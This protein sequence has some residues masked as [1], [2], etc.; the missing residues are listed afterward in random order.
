MFVFLL[1]DSPCVCGIQY[2]LSPCDIYGGWGGVLSDPCYPVNQTIQFNYTFLPGEGFK[3][4]LDLKND[5]VN[6][7]ED[8]N[9]PQIIESN[10]SKSRLLQ[11]INMKNK[12]SKIQSEN[13]INPKKKIP[14]ENTPTPLQQIKKIRNQKLE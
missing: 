10:S 8:I 2:S 5:F 13:Q 14:R 1:R 6:H 4:P 3:P 7:N 11:Q 12:N 9:R